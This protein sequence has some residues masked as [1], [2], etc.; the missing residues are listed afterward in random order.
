MVVYATTEPTEALVFGGHTAAMHEGRVMDF[1][2][3]SEIYRKPR[4]LATARVFSEP[5]INIAH[6]KKSGNR[7]SLN[8]NVGW[9]AGAKLKELAD[10]DYTIGIRPHHVSPVKTG[11]GKVSIN[12][13]VQVAELS[14][15]ES[16]IHFD[17]YGHSWVSLSHGVHP[18]R[19]GEEATLYADVAHC[20]YFDAQ[21]R[22]ISG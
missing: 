6:V 16:I 12:G 7:I 3:T 2:P 10:G 4:D 18:F 11:R 13:T 17:A 8:E 21:N 22:L 20:L 14:G 19:A 5:P 9:N 1:G 15:S